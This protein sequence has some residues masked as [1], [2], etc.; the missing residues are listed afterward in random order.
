MKSF[1][2]KQIC[3]LII[4]FVASLALTGCG[5]DF[6]LSE[7]E[8]AAYNSI[9]ATEATLNQHF[10]NLQGRAI[11]IDFDNS[12]GTPRVLST[13]LLTEMRR[14]EMAQLE[15][16]RAAVSLDRIEMRN[17]AIREL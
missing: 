8:V 11:R 13:N 10:D 9:F 5:D 7:N 12:T 2:L 6:Y 17:G 3:A 14:T 4:L 16:G 15:S 1:E